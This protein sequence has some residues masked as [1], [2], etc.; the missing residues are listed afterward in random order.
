M[1]LTFFFLFSFTYS[2][3]GAVVKEENKREILNKLSSLKI[4]FIENKGQINE[5]VSYYAK[6]FGGTVFITQ[7]GRLIY[8][9]PAEKGGVVLK[10]IF[11]GSK[12]KTVKGEKKAITKVNYFLGKDRKKWLTDLATYNYV[13]LG[14]LWQGIRL[15][16]R[17]Y[18]NNV[19]KLFYVEPGA[20]AKNIKVRIEGAKRLE[21]AE[22]GRLKVITEKGYIC[23]TKPFAYQEIDG[24]RKQIK[25]AYVIR[26]DE[27][28]FKLGK[29]DQTKPI[30]IDPLLASTYLGGGN[31]DG[32]DALALDPSGN[33]YVAGYT[34]SSD[35]PTTIGAYDKDYNGVDDGFI[36]KLS[37]DLSNLLAS[38][39]LGG[40]DRDRLNALA[41]DQSGN[42]YVAG[43][44]ESSDFPTT[45]GA[46]DKD[47]NGYYD[48]FIS[49]LNSDLNSLLAST[50]LGGEGD[51]WLAL[52][53]DQSGNVYVAGWTW[54][55]DFPTTTGAYDKDCNGGN[56]N[57]VSKLDANLS[58]AKPMPW[59]HLLLGD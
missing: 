31:A 49:K 20:K 40:K 59:L 27:Y 8:N 43:W 53:L 21:L 15:K 39:Y 23:F 35:F 16:V 33:V 26:G 2:A 32:A 7:K 10:E 57:F 45:D 52:A 12:A 17:A 22:D 11:I 42:V 1:V 9:L 36:S 4:P 3:M 34:Y 25:V 47:Y 38:T 19:E 37:S 18:G 24:K 58:G 13:S 48:A 51:D 50:Y 6:T 29:Y 46:Y 28:T 41:L 56:D 5:S 30:V 14:E 54:S 44:T 55:S